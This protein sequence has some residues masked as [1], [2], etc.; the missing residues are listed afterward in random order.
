[1]MLHRH[2][3]EDVFKNGDV[4]VTGLEVSEGEDIQMESVSSE[5][6]VDEIQEVSRRRRGPKPHRSIGEGE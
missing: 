1:M 4:V 6:V 5:N 2:Q 3:A